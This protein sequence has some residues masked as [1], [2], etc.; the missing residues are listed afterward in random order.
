[1]RYIAVL[2]LIL[3]SI[4]YCQFR[5]TKWGWT[6]EQVKK[7]EKNKIISDN[8]KLILYEGFI[9][10]LPATI[11]YGFNEGRLDVGGYSFKAK[12]VNKNNYIEDYSKLKKALIAKYGEP[13]KTNVKWLNDL[14]QT[15]VENYGLA[16]SVGHLEF[17]TVWE[18][19][20]FNIT[21]ML[22]GENF[23]SNL[24]LYYYSNYYYNRE[25]DT[26]DL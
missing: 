14:Y 7:T 20:E 6:H 4:S 1:M 2:L 8:E 18:T 23:E 24:S 3:P 5:A 25:P 13:E 26:S 9:Q 19:N 11:V 21:L 16:V 15:D 12:Y 17:N 10:N 22:N